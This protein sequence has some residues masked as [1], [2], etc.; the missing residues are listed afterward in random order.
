VSEPALILLVED[1][2]DNRVLARKLLERAGFRVA[3]ATDGRQALDQVAAL[4]P[5]LVLLD[6]SLPEVDGWTVARTL[7]RSP[8]F[9]DLRIVA[10]TAHAMEG[11]RERVLEAGCDEFLTKPIEI[12]KFIPSIRR[13][14]ERGRD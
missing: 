9:K 2:P 4:R 5:D 7:R 11:D 10:L 6:M 8:E 1:H 3:E 12:P 13:V 14:L